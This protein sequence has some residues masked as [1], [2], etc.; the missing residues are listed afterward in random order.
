MLRKELSLT[1]SEE[2]FIMATEGRGGGRGG[3]FCDSFVALVRQKRL[4]FVCVIALLAGA[5][6]FAAVRRWRRERS[7]VGN[8]W[9]GSRLLSY[10]AKS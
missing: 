4:C 8:R 10:V 9:R 1:R 3:G 5:V 6:Y 2:E 7:W